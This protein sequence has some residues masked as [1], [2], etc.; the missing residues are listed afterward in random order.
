MKNKTILLIDDDADIVMLLDRFLTKKGYTVHKAM[1][2]AKGRELIHEHKIDLVLCDFRL[3]DAKGLDVLQDIKKVSPQTQV[4]II[5][6]KN[7]P[8]FCRLMQV[9]PTP[10]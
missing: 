10:N 8:Y 7:G 3:P 4:I 5:I 2:A 1:N 6:S 9:T